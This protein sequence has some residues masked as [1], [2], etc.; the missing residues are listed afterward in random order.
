MRVAG[1]TS[2][3]SNGSQEMPVNL[4]TIYVGPPTTGKSQAL[5]ECAVSPIPLSA[6]IYDVLFKLLKFDEENATRNIQG[7]K[8]HTDMPQRVLERFFTP[9]FASLAQPK[10]HSPLVLSPRDQP[11]A[12]LAGPSPHQTEQA[13]QYLKTSPITGCDNIFIKIKQ[14]HSNR[15]TYCLT[16]D[17]SEL[18]KLIH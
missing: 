10:Y 4:L 3:L 8:A 17:T 11:R 9:P 1:M 6:K 14:L 18:V 16:E 7:N 15:T 5:K 13:L 12:L 2:T